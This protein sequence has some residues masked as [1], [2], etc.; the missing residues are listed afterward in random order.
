MQIK[1]KNEAKQYT[2]TIIMNIV[3]IKRKSEEI[4]NAEM[5]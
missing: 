4:T 5:W 1:P 3:V 2:F